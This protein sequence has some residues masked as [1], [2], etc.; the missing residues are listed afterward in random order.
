[1]DLRESVTQVLSRS[2]A[3]MRPSRIAKKLL[4]DFRL[5]ATRRRVQ[6]CLRECPE[7]VRDDRGAW[8]CSSSPQHRP[9]PDENGKA[10]SLE[11]ARQA[12]VDSD[13]VPLS[14]NEVWGAAER[15]G[16]RERLN[17]TGLTPKDNVMEALLRE[18]PDGVSFSP[19]TLRLLRQ[20]I[21]LGDSQIEA[22][23]AQMFQMGDDRLWFSNEMILDEAGQT[24][25]R[26][27][28]TTWLAE[29]GCFSV[30]R[31]LEGFCSVLRH[32]ATSEDFE[33]LLGHLGFTVVQWGEGVRF[34]FQS[35]PS[36]DERLA[37]ASKTIADL[38]EG[39]GGVLALSDVE[40]AMPHL[41]T[42]ALDGIRTRF[43]PEVHDA[44]V[45]EL[46]CWR[47]AEAVHLPEDFAEKLTDA[48]DALVALGDRVTATRLQFAL[49]L[50]YRVRFREE[51]AL[52][53]NPTF[54]RVCAK[55]YRDYSLFCG[56]MSSPP[57]WKRMLFL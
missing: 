56:I 10:S 18:Y 53:D 57:K 11:L 15:L 43:L 34:C 40:Q 42:E 27:Q 21:S 9:A 14:P 30:E 20:R 8:S 29:Q 16:L 3:P 51:Y 17:S 25:L 33:A 38:L 4:K 26:K 5:R 23:K 47:T 32:V 2:A 19:M 1:M 28:A 31:L 24:A 35:P 6:S 46:P 12:L 45:G 48:V 13:N 55:H 52:Q 36:L 49:N 41:T 37:G 39:A 44:E 22:L 7:F 54:M 50:F